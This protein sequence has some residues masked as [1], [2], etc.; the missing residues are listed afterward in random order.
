MRE[1]VCHCKED[2]CKR[3]HSETLSPQGKINGL[4]SGSSDLVSVPGAH[5]SWD[6]G[7][8]SCGD[9]VPKVWTLTAMVGRHS[10]GRG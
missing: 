7:I 1:L 10:R 4:T 9:E 5:R 3:G 8:R 6:W 2:I